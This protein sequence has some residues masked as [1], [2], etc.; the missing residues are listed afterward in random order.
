MEI[1]VL[2]LRGD[3]CD[4]WRVVFFCRLGLILLFGNWLELEKKLSFETIF[5]KV[6]LP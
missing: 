5:T 2:L 3:G 1:I 4:G 6:L